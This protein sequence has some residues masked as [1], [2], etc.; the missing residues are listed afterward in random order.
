M[1]APVPLATAATPMLR[2]YLLG[3]LRIERNAQPIRLPTRKVESL[4]VY[5][6]LHPEP[7]PREKLAALL[8][9]DSSDELAR[10]SLRT[11]LTTLRKALGDDIL[12][13]DR[14]TVQVNPD[15]SVWFD[16]LHLAQAAADDPQSAIALYQG[17][18]LPDF[19][20]DWIL[21]ERERLRALYLDTLLRLAQ[22]ARSR[23]EYAQAMDWA[24]KVLASDPANEKAYQHLIFC[25]AAL[26]DRIG[27]LK[28][29]DEC[30]RKLRDELGVEPSKETVAL[31]DQIEQAL[32]GGQAHEA[33]FT[34]VP[35]PLT[36]FIGRQVEI[37][38]IMRLLETTRLVTLTG[39]GGCGKTRL[40]IQV[41]TE[42]ANANRFKHG[43]W[44]V[45]LAP[46]ADASLVPHAVAQALGVREAP[47]QSLEET[48]VN[49]LRGKR[50]L[51]VL[52]NCEHLIEACAILADKLLS[53]CA[54]LTILATSREALGITGEAAWRVPSLALPDAEILLPIEQL[55]Q[56]DAVRLFAERAGTIAATWKLSDHTLAVAHVCRRLDGIPLAIELAVARLKVLSVEQIAARLD[57]RFSLLTGGSRTAPP[58]QQ[59]LRAT[60]EWSYDLLSD[61]ERALLRRL[62]V[63]AGGST[64]EAAESVCVDE[65]VKAID[66]LDLLARLVDKSLV[67]VEER[68]SVAR[69]RMLETVRQFAH[70]KL[71]ESD[72]ELTVRQ[73]H[74]NY[75]L[76]LAQ[77]ADTKLYGPE[78]FEWLHRLD[79]EHNN[80]RSALEWSLTKGQ[81]DQ[82][83]ELAVALFKFWHLGGY[84]NEGREWVAHL[85]DHPQ[86]AARNLS[87]ANGLM[88]AGLLNSVV[89]DYKASRRYLEELVPLA[90]ELGEAGKQPLALALGYLSSTTFGDTLPMAESML[91]E[92]LTIA[93]SLG[94]QWVIARLLWLKGRFLCG[95]N[96]FGGGRESYAEALALWQSIGDK[97]NSAYLMIY[98]GRMYFR[99]KDFLTARQY[100]EQSLLFARQVRDRETI[101]D[102]L[103]GLGE[104][105]RA[106][107]D[108]DFAKRCQ[109]EGLEIARELGQMQVVTIFLNNLA[110]IALHLGDLGLA[111]S[112]LSESLALAREL[113]AKPLIIFSLLGF[114]GVM[115]AEKKGR[116]AAQLLAV[117][118]TF[119][120]A[121]DSRGMNPADEAQHQHNLAI[122]RAQMDDATF[123]AAWQEGLAMS[124]EQ[125]IELALKLD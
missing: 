89:G 84:W 17:D 64:I 25:S 94:T 45:D 75:Y 98:V 8:W 67:I 34:N 123:N 47:N 15:R 102:D 50:L 71:L 77:R 87:R 90:R 26:G 22:H 61:A 103:L 73:R 7:H 121:G 2:V 93:R 119:L 44:W 70:D 58:R 108:Y 19:Y 23:S 56:Y 88:V 35:V 65:R 101:A 30:E 78:Q 59:T 95:K 18:L 91:E 39:S 100:T 10:R 11:A 82:G 6:I 116:R 96:D 20:D 106:E 105:A 36:S 38:E 54:E 53:A 72:P 80:L 21:V 41:A 85:L 99:N 13:A 104:I 51:L 1:M 111:K 110:D 118:T 29:F 112:R 69:Y 31:R 79:L 14:E 109:L 52:D 66:V 27:A 97:R 63:F 42:L 46:L 55:T 4:L 117:Y 120:E 60:V 57:D 28:Q 49:Y 124:F 5:L 48:L 86:A 40:A 32:T 37:P 125:A 114:A 81:A 115:A 83:L 33:L 3:A 43:V 122:T 74:F 107:G 76:T 16:A 68:E 92:G 12:L 113:N 9:G 24:Q 62:S